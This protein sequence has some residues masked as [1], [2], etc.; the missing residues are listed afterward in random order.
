[1]QS[2]ATVRFDPRAARLGALSGIPLYFRIEAPS[3]SVD[4][5]DAAPVTGDDVCSPTSLLR[6]I[7][8]LY[9]YGYDARPQATAEERA[10]APA[11]WITGQS[12][13]ENV[14]HRADY[15]AVLRKLFGPDQNRWP[16]RLRLDFFD[17]LWHLAEEDQP[18]F[19]NVGEALQ[20]FEWTDGVV[21]DD[22]SDAADV[23]DYV[24]RNAARITYPDAAGLRTWAQVYR[25]HD[26]LARQLEDS[27]RRFSPST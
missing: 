6:A 8:E 14:M 10:V 25:V 5:S 2:G 24:R 4:C 15:V 7:Y 23:Q 12:S 26:A 19:A 9:N 11:V 21:P 20:E 16:E 17:M 1:M 22:P 27:L 13:P 3:K 18:P